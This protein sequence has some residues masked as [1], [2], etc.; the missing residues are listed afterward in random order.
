MTVERKV[1]QL[2]DFSEHRCALNAVKPLTLAQPR[3]DRLPCEAVVPHVTRAAR[4]DR[5]RDSVVEGHRRLPCT[6]EGR[7][8]VGVEVWVVPANP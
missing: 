2:H 3:A 8:V 5:I 1:S 7:G 6:L 4:N